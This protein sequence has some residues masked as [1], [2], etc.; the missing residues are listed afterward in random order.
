MGRQ[1]K[2]WGLVNAIAALMLRFG[3]ALRAIA[4]QFRAEQA[5][6][7]RTVQPRPARE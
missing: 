2:S 3:D 6:S 7:M 4:A 1:K 5:R